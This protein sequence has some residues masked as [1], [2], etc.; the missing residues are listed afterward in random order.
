MCEFASFIL[1][2]DS[3][4]WLPAEDSYEQIISHF[5]LHAERVRGP[6]ILRVK[7]RP[8]DKIKTWPQLEDWNFIIDQDKM[9]AWFDRHDDEKRAREALAERFLQGFGR[10]DAS[11]CTALTELK[12]DAAEYVYAS[13]C[14]ALTE[15]KADAAEYVDASGCTALTGKHGRKR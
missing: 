10:I 8:T 2:K 4:F 6:N 1:T 3:V 5:N 15:L 14:T 11:G 12:A 13:G 7:I 9:P